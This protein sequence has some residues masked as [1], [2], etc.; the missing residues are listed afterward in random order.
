MASLTAGKWLAV[1][2]PHRS[3][4]PAGK[5][6]ATPGPLYMLLSGYATQGPTPET[7][8]TLMWVI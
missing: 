7:R 6:P 4:R 3:W 1:P 5:V 2:R 8:S